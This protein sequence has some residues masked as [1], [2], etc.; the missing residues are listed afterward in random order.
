MK[1][2]LLKEAIADAKAVRE[3]ALANAKVALEEAFAPRIQSMLSAKLAEEMEEEDSDLDFPMESADYESESEMS[4]EPEM[5]EETEMSDEPEMKAEP[6]PEDEPEITEEDL[7]LESI[8]REL[9]GEDELE[10]E[11]EMEPTMEA[12]EPEDEEVDLNELLDSLAEEEE[13]EKEPEPAKKE[14]SVEELAEAYRTIKYLRN[15]INEVNMLNAKL[16]FTNKLFK[17]FEMNEAQK[18]KV[19]ETFDRATSLRE[20]KLVYATLSESFTSRRINSRKRKV[21]E[22]ASRVTRTTKPTKEII[23]ENA[24]SARMKKLAGL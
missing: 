18:L 11:P 10:L 7:D 8:I 17:N 3:S 19:I 5:S 15:Q 1:N 21:N 24:F 13:V 16:L 23:N 2:E 4:D 9:E 12:D 14:K 6:E 20:V 22:S